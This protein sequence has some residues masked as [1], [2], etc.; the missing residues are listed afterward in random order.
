VLFVDDEPL[1]LRSLDRALRMRKVP[2]EAHFIDTSTGALELLASEQFD[3]VVADLR[4]PVLDGVALLTE[5]QRSYPRIARL[6]LSGQV[7]TDDCLRAMRVAHQCLAKPCNIDTL[8]RLIQRLQTS[9]RLLDDAE[10]ATSATQLSSL[11]SAP[12]VHAEVSTA[13]ASGAG[14]A[15]IAQ[16]IDG[17]VAVTAKLIQV[18]NSAFFTQGTAVT[19]V[20]RAL[21]VLG[22]DVVRNLLLSIEV[23]RGFEGRGLSLARV[24]RLRRHSRFVAQLAHTLAPRGLAGDAYVAGMLHDIGDLV[25]T[26]LDRPPHHLADHGRAGGFLLGLWGMKDTIADSITYHHAPGEITGDAMPLGDLL[27]VSELVAGELEHRDRA[28]VE[29]LDPAWLARNDAS[30]L[31]LARRTGREIWDQLP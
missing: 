23:F 14:L 12:Q 1:V 16:I 24:E 21:I 26:C 22:T 15:E 10:L 18:V 9:Q 29:P 3:V 7:G 6:V 28:P 13:I 2:W 19:T 8:R 31:E 20:Q 25:L 17:D 27:Y 30:V 5:I 11:P 4:I